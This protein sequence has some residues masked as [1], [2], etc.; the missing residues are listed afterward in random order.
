MS[1]SLTA[2]NID[3]EIY[4][5]LADLTS[6]RAGAKKIARSFKADD[7]VIFD[8]DREV[9]RFLPSMGFP[10]LFLAGKFGNIF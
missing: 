3:L 1:T 4:S 9:N 2:V 5:E 7:L 10:K 6:R 8:L